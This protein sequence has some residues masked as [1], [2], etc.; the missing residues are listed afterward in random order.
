MFHYELSKRKDNLVVHIYSYSKGTLLFYEDETCSRKFVSFSNV[1]ILNITDYFQDWVS[2]GRLGEREA[3]VK[4]I[5]LFE[6]TIQHVANT[7]E[8]DDYFREVFLK[9]YPDISKDPETTG[10]SAILSKLMRL[11]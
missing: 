5:D 4:L 1:K 10:M 3:S 2:T 9:L 6:F 7:I 8:E 11:S